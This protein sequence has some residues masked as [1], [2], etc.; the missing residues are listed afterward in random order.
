MIKRIVTAL[1]VLAL[2]LAGTAS[3]ARAET[4]QALRARVL[5]QCNEEQILCLWNGYNYTG[6]MWKITKASLHGGGNGYSFVGSGINNASKGWFNRIDQ[7]IVLYDHDHCNTA[8]WSR[9]LY[10]GQY[11]VS[12]DAGTNDWENRISSASLYTARGIPC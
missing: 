6:T 8:P 11:A 3:S 10:P 9:I 1:A 5:E 7:T 12:Y 2:V 4:S